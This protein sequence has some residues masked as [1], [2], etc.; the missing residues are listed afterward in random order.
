MPDAVT[1][2][3]F[4]S[5]HF[6]EV[7]GAAFVLLPDSSRVYRVT[8][9]MRARLHTAALLG[10]E[11]LKDLARLNHEKACD[12][13][14]ALSAIKGLTI[15]NQTFFNEFVVKFDKPAKDII[16]ALAHEDMIPGLRLDEHRLLVCATEMTTAEDIKALCDGLRGAL[17]G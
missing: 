1:A 8:S 16:M 12:L 11:G 2:P 3:K 17:N 7:D 4:P 13:A 5:I 14:D 6:F 9:E 15:E 10:E